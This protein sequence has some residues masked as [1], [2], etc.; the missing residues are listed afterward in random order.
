MNFEVNNKLRFLFDVQGLLQRWGLDAIQANTVNIIFGFF[1]IVL[2]AWLAD[3]VTRKVIVV[4]ISRMVARTRTLWDDILLEKKVFT[5]I[6]HLAPAIVLWYSVGH[7]LYQYPLL[8]SVTQKALSIFMI[9]V[10][11]SAIN[12]FL[13]GLNDIYRTLPASQ[14]RSIK[15]YIQVVQ[16]I[17]YSVA[18]ISIVSTITGTP[19][20]KLITG[21]GAAAAVLLLVFK[22]TILGLVAGIQLSSN[23][24][25]R[26]GDW[27]T[28]TKYGADGHVIEITLIT[29]K[30]RNFDKTITT[31]PTYALVS[32]SFINWRGTEEESARRFKK[33]LNIDMKTV[34]FCSVA[35]LTRLNMVKSIKEYTDRQDKKVR[36]NEISSLLHEGELTNLTLFR[37]YIVGVLRNH[38]GL[39]H[40]LP[41]LVRQL[42][43]TEYGIPLEIIAF[44]KGTDG[45][46]FEELQS[47][48]FDHLLAVLPD[49][50]LSV[51]QNPVSIAEKST[52]KRQQT[53]R[54]V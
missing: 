29:V 49:F 9:I 28:M 32:D 23:D 4:V 53:S 43:P 50:E 19:A 7:V 36:K 35:L 13:K 12:A 8:M 10:T 40:K 6:A 1:I 37:K 48:L 22:D 20:G 17:F 24:M 11:L 52:M 5:K 25:L 18:I 33:Y 44:V 45:L 15:G 27:I 39:N 54:D 30:V 51:F 3:I 21:L 31:I 47:D 26:L 38:S 41:M 34:S 16:I 42:Q 14:G 46:V 2:L